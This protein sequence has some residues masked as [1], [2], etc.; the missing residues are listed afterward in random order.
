MYGNY[1]QGCSIDP[2][3]SKVSI[4]YVG[5]FEWRQG[6]WLFFNFDGSIEEGRYKNGRQVGIWTTTDPEGK[7]HKENWGK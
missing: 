1:G 2:T 6:P 5:E 7:E 3:Y 4:G